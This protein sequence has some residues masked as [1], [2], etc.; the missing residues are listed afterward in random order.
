MAVMDTQNLA[1]ALNEILILSVL[2]AEPK[3]GYQIAVEI[4]ERSDGRFGFNHG[5]LYPILHHLEKE[6]LIDGDWQEGRGRRKKEYRL[7][8]AGRQ[9]LAR[10]V[11]EWDELHGHLFAF[12]VA[13]EAVPARA[14]AAQ[15]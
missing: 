3:H 6:Q 9:H 1:R 7:T 2:L 14:A 15:R 5:T 11:A 10:R 13:S 12:L 4:E 8:A